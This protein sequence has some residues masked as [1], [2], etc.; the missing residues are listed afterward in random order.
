MF[1]SSGSLL[2]AVS[3][4]S[5]AEPLSSLIKWCFRLFE[6]FRVDIT[7]A[8]QILAGLANWS[9]NAETSD[10]W[11]TSRGC[12]QP[13]DDLDKHWKMRISLIEKTLAK[14]LVQSSWF[15]RDVRCWL[16]GSSWQWWIVLN[17]NLANGS[18]PE[19]SSLHKIPSLKRIF[20]S[21]SDRVQT[22]RISM[23]QMRL[24]QTKI[25]FAVFGIASEIVSLGYGYFS[26]TSFD[27]ELRSWALTKSFD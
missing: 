12:G 23:L 3:L 10:Y 24:Q 15:T 14:Y 25:G 16:D 7:S 27:W 2:A 26:A 20:R 13:A 21:Q 6:K 22:V 17:R 5:T 1:S 9:E 8:L 19:P 18:N 11:Q 4:I